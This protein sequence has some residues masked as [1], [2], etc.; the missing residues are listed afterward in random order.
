LNSAAPR[1][2]V[3]CTDLFGR[4]GSPWLNSLNYCSM[5]SRS[6][7]MRFLSRTTIGVERPVCE[8]VQ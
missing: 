6:T 4:I 2:G 7:S 3:G 1:N 5:R 8:D